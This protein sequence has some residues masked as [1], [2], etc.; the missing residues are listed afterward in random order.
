M[1]V[2]IYVEE[3]A[4]AISL[5]CFCCSRIQRLAMFLGGVSTPGGLNPFIFSWAV[6]IASSPKTPVRMMK[7]D[8]TVSV[9][10]SAPFLP[11]PHHRKQSRRRRSIDSSSTVYTKLHLSQ[12]LR[13]FSTPCTS[14]CW[15]ILKLRKLSARPNFSSWQQ[16]TFSR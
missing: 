7:R 13:P 14:R 1:P 5:V 16:T 8:H 6:A 4:D 2:S 11:L 12:W 15:L 3:C 9:L 10:N